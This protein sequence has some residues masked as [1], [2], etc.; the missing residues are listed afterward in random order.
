MQVVHSPYFK[1]GI[2]VISVG[3]F[4]LITTVKTDF[5]PE[6]L[7]TELRRPWCANQC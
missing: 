7:H 1:V 2:P 6:K 3:Y 4:L 5:S